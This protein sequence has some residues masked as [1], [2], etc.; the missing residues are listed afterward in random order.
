MNFG[1]AE[2]QESVTLR[3]SHPLPV[4]HYLYVESIQPFTEMVK[5]KTGGKVQ[6]EVFPASQLGKDAYATLTSGLAD[7]SMII[8]FYAGDKFPG[9]SVTELPNMST[10][11]CG[12]T[13]KYWE[14]AQNGGTLAEEEYG[15]AGLRVLFVNSSVPYPLMNSKKQVAV[16]QDA[17]G[18]KVW[19]PGAAMSKAARTV[20]AVPVNFPAPELFDSLKRGTIDGAILL[21]P[22]ANQ[23]D[24]QGE[25]QY[26]TEGVSLG[27]GAWFI[28]ME[29]ERW[30]KLPQDV[31]DAIDDAAGAAQELAC[32]FMDAE[33][34]RVRTAW[35]EERGIEFY[36]PTEDQ[37]KVWSERLETVA[38]QWVEEMDQN[39]RAGTKLLE[40]MTKA[41]N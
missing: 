40:A 9:T 34:K 1:M 18:L 32:E 12:A 33:N 15:P 28:G 24:L 17:E 5:E 13:E 25:I 14:L 38:T 11:S 21:L 23:Y 39:G 20:G 3:L 10:T 30:D 41:G 27:T 22:S 2:A 36:Q 37:M 29:Q 8:P 26:V 7:L 6:F 16:P 35:I 4:N 31:R 19:A